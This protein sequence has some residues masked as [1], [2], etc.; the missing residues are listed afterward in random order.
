MKTE[1]KEKF[2]MSIDAFLP[3]DQRISHQIKCVKLGQ[4]LAMQDNQL[5]KEIIYEKFKNI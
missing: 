1:L 4:L 3:I 2:Q 5:M